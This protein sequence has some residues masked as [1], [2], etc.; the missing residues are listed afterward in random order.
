MAVIRTDSRALRFRVEIGLDFDYAP[1]GNRDHP[2]RDQD[3]RDNDV[4][5]LTQ[6]LLDWFEPQVRRHPDQW[7][8]FRRFFRAAPTPTLTLE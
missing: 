7:Y 5:A 8:M 4:R 2:A 3:A 1:T 6:S